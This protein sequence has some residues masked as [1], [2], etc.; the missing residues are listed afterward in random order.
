[1]RIAVFLSALLTGLTL[2]AAPTVARDAGVAEGV[3][4]Q[5]LAVELLAG[6]P[7]KEVVTHVYTFRG[8]TVLPWHIHP[9][10]HEIAYV[11]EGD[12]VIEIEGEDPRPL[13]PGESFYLPPGVV[14]RGMNRG[15]G[16][17]RLFVARIKPVDEPLAVEVRPPR[18]D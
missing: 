11:L 18:P 16:P 13:K 3:T 2:W 7:D 15:E 4:A 8:G 10:A 5:E 14:H 17:V 12:F 1:M 6:D 9:G